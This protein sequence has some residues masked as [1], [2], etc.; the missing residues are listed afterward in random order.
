MIS[1]DTEKVERGLLGIIIVAG[2]VGVITMIPEV[3]KYGLSTG[4]P[5]PVLWFLLWGGIIGGSGMWWFGAHADEKIAQMIFVGTGA[6]TLVI[7]WELVVS[8]G[9]S[10]IVGTMVAMGVSALGTMLIVVLAA[11]ALDNLERKI[12]GSPY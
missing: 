1:M 5:M 6:G 2:I 12:A 11:I 3:V 10:K 9:M 8:F 7:G 4:N